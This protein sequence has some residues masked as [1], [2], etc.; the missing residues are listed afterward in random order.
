[1]RSK[2]F[3]G[4]C[5]VGS[6]AAIAL[7]ATGCGGDTGT[8]TTSTG[9]GGSTGGTGPTTTSSSTT[10]SNTTTSTTTSTTTT[11][12]GTGGAAGDGND[13]FDQAVAV[14]SMGV[15]GTLEDPSVDADYYKFDG[16]AGDTWLISA[17]SHPA[18]T[19]TD[20][21]Y[22][23][24][25]IEL[26]D[27]NKKLVATNDD[28]Y[29]RQNTDS[30]IITVLPTTGTYYV[31][32]LEWCISPTKDVKA[33]DQTYTD[34][35][36]NLDYTIGAIALD[37]TKGDFVAEKE[38]NDSAA[39]ASPIAPT[40]TTTKGSYF[41]TV[42][43]GKL[44][45]SSDSDWYSVT[46]PANLTVAAGSRAHVGFLN[47]WGGTAGNGS[48][49]KVGLVD[50]IDATTMAVV[51]SFDLSNEPGAAA[52]RADLSVPVTPGSN[53][54]LKVKHG[55]VEADGGGQF[56]FMYQTL[57]AGNPLEKADVT[58]SL[59][60]TPE[61]VP[62]SATKGSYFV[63]GN[64][65]VGD[66]DHF[67]VATLGEATISIACSA[68]RGGSGLRG[69][70][71]SVF[72]ADGTTPV[73]MGTATETATKDLFIDHLPIPAN[74][75]DLVIKIAAPAAPDATNTGTYYICGFH[76]GPVPAP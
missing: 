47:P 31:K 27:A 9:T 15:P 29:P 24:T 21:G 43:E 17:S 54:L 32:I 61:V 56:Y 22:I 58:N 38:P 67:K 62:A 57:G 76:V 51:G 28:R 50:V 2:H 65:T 39:T 1:M 30:E 11:T 6:F 72:N 13:S 33:C 20:P 53:Y 75:T 40:E 71:A 23:D 46:I 34:S 74:Q 69:F 60:A 35:L 19:D 59:P 10:G 42:V 26:Y 4:L 16:K 68:Q 5:L 49:V 8:G 12:S 3:L 41:L 25:F 45:M 18:N 48:D 52:G 63:E 66:L 36:V 44:P 64:L 55:G 73:A 70:T 37:S 7:A 14:D